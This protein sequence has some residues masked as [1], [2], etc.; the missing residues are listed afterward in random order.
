MREC[1]FSI[2]TWTTLGVCSGRLDV[3]QKSENARIVKMLIYINFRRV[4]MLVKMLIYINLAKLFVIDHL[5]KY[6]EL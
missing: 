6:L 5:Q 4:K 2:K 3:V 1:L